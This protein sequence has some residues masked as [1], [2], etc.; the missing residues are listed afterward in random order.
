[1]KVNPKE[2]KILGQYDGVFEERQDIST[3]YIIRIIEN[4]KII[5][6]IAEERLTRQKH[7][8]EFPINAIKYCLEKA[9]CDLSEVSYIANAYSVTIGNN[10]LISSEN[11]VEEWHFNRKH[12][13]S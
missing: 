13:T 10:Q 3:G 4:G 5:F 11:I 6:A 2:L 8:R 1:M 7:T 12:N 9:E